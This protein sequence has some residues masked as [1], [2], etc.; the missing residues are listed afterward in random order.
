MGCSKERMGNIGGIKVEYIATVDT[1][2]DR[3]VVCTVG[4]VR[5]RD[6]KVRDIEVSNLTQV[7]AF[8]KESEGYF[9]SITYH[10][11]KL[12]KV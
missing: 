7:K 10:I 4:K 11:Y 5:D 2:F 12:V 8:V 1:N 3:E 9:P 6:G